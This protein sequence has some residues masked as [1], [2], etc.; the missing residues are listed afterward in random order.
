MHEKEDEI[1]R[2]GQT[3][4]ENESEEAPYSPLGHKKIHLY[5]DQALPFYNF[6]VNENQVLLSDFTD[7]GMDNN[8]N[9]SLLE[10][11]NFQQSERKDFKHQHSHDDHVN[12]DSKD[13]IRVLHQ[14][15]IDYLDNCKLQ[16]I[17]E[18]GNF[19]FL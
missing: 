17:K 13:C 8:Y 6:E 19:F 3:Y 14:G 16:H 4:N 7:V 12:H 9:G 2:D 1:P 15:H 18:D 11:Y 10:T 5:Q